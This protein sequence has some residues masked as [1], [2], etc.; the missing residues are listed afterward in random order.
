MFS[1]QNTPTNL[2]QVSIVVALLST[3]AISS[4]K[5]AESADA[6]KSAPKTGFADAGKS[7]SKSGSS[8]SGKAAPR[9]GAADAGKTAQ[10][11]E[12]GDAGKSTSGL[13]PKMGYKLVMKVNYFGRIE[14]SVSP[15]GAR[16]TSPMLAITCRPPLF[17]THLY[18]T[19]TKK[20]KIFDKKAGYDR[21]GAM[22]EGGLTSQ[23]AKY[24]YSAWKKEGEDTV[25]GRKCTKFTRY[26]TNAP[27]DQQRYAKYLEEYWVTP[28][29][30]LPHIDDLMAPLT[31][32]T[33]REFNLMKGFG[34]KRVTTWQVFRRGVSKP[35]VDDKLIYLQTLECKK[36]MIDPKIFELG[37][38]Y[39]PVKDEGEILFSDDGGG[40]AGR[41]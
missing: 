10:K 3:F 14:W 37:A 5:P 41:F 7:T 18:N 33:S 34:M 17:E 40:F 2:K 1:Q 9:S 32:L 28:F 8:E 6:A 25:A 13:K 38:D 26:M 22:M 39:T 24:K 20:V 19:E 21:L 12:A 31:R 4:C 11:S 27:Q 30:D 36:M 35:D 23:H 15:D 16:L 29:F